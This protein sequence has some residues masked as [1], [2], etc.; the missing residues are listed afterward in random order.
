MDKCKSKCYDKNTE[1]I[2]PN[3]LNSQKKTFDF[4]FDNLLDENS[5]SKCSSNNY[6]VFFP[7]I[8]FN[9][10]EVLNLIY[11]IKNWKDCNDY[12]LKF[13]NIINKKTIERI[14]TYSWASFYETYKINIEYI[15]EIY[16]IYLNLIGNN[17]DKNKIQDKIYELKKKDT[18]KQ[19]FH[20]LLLSNFIKK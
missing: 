15:T 10:K 12:F 2:N 17:N 1:G 14:I 3:Y 9:E 20:K 11:D 4:C 19:E 6:N 7:I 18:N 16:D 13:K 8:N 5:V